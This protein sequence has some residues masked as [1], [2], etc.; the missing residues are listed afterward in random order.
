M[1]DNE[2]LEDLFNK[3]KNRNKKKTFIN[4][5]SDELSKEWHECVAKPMSEQVQKFVDLGQ[6]KVIGHV[7]FWL[8][9]EDTD[10]NDIKKILLSYM[11]D[12]VDMRANAYGVWG[13]LEEDLRKKTDSQ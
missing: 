9:Q 3:L 6:A 8:S 7:L 5:K 13:D 2:R 12:D 10:K 1:E 11:K 4:Q